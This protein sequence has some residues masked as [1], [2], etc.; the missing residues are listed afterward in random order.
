MA[1]LKTGFEVSQ[2]GENDLRH[3]N[4]ALLLDYWLFKNHID[5]RRLDPK[6]T[7]NWPRSGQF[8]VNIKIPPPGRRGIMGVVIFF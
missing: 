6:F 3:P 2:A 5:N 1:F 4:S 8:L 7:R